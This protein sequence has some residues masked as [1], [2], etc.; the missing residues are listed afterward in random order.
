MEDLS[1]GLTPERSKDPQAAYWDVESA[2]DPGKEE[3]KMK[4]IF[5]I[6]EYYASPKLSDL[7]FSISNQCQKGAAHR[8]I[9]FRCIFFDI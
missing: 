2:P 7:I 4:I 3:F 1:G 6:P 9:L 8:N 5:V